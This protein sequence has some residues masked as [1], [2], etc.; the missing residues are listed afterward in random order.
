MIR[1]SRRIRSSFVVGLLAS[2]SGSAP[3]YLRAQSAQHTSNTSRPIAL[4]LALEGRDSAVTIAGRASVNS[5]QLQSTSFDVAVQ[6]AS[7]GVRV[8]SRSLRIAVHEG[9]SLVAT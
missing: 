3:G 9:D 5:G 7:G 2:V 6:D 4:A 8:F 1:R